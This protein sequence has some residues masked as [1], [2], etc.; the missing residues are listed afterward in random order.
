MRTP[1][2]NSMPHVYMQRYVAH[3]HVLSRPSAFVREQGTTIGSPLPARAASLGA[4]NGTHKQSVARLNG[5]GAPQL[6][7][8]LA[9]EQLECESARAHHAR[10]SLPDGSWHPLRSVRFERLSV[11]TPCRSHAE[12]CR[13][14]WPR[15]HADTPMDV[16]IM[17]LQGAAMCTDGG[18]HAARLL[19]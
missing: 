5:E 6:Q 19:T 7:R 16:Q 1:L 18:L 4:H 12:L 8:H 2:A 14:A 11:S 3:C 15:L 17:H 13:P 9:R 10:V